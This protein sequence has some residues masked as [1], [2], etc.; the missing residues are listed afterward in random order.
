MEKK[1]SYKKLWIKLRCMNLKKKDLQK[2]TNLS[3]AV[4]AKLGKNQCVN[5]ET[6]VKICSALNC[7]L[8]DIVEIC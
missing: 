8:S 2:L 1:L 7:N 5:M 6:L 3:S 4:I